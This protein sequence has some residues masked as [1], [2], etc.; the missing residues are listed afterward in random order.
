[1]FTLIAIFTLA[2]G[3]GANTAIF[4]VVRGVLLKPLPFDDADRLVGVWHTAPGI[5]IPELNMSP[6]TYLIYREEGRVFED[7]GLWNG[8]AV[9]VTGSG[10]PE[11]VQA[12]FVTDGTLSLLHVNPILGRHFTADD[13]SPRTP[14]RVLVSHAYWERKFGSDRD[15]VGKSVVVDGKPR[16]IIGVLP[17]G[18]RFP[19]RNP[20]LVLPFR[21]NRSE[22]HAAN[23]SYR[24]VARLKPGTTM[25]QANADV[26][27]LIPV[28]PDRFPMPPGFTRK[29][30]DDVKMGPN[31]RPLAV[32]VVGDIG[33]V[34]WVLLGTVGLVLLIA[35]ANVANLFLVRAEARQ[36]E[37]AI[38]A[39]LGAGSL[40]IAWELLSESL[41]LA[42]AGGLA[43]LGL[44]YAGIRALVANAPEGLPRTAD[45]GIDPIVLAF[46]LGI[47]LLAGVLFGLLPVLKLATPHLASAL[48]EGGRLA[49]A[50]RERH[51][52]RNGLVVAEIAL[53]VV[54]LVA[55]GLMIRTFQ[56][57]R[58]VAPGF[59]R[60]EEVLTLRVSIPES[61][62]A[63]GGQAIRTHEQIVRRIEQIPGVTSVGVSNSIT[64]DGFDSNDP[65][66]VED[67]PPPADTIPPLRRFKFTAQNYFQTMGN[68]IVA[69]RE[70]TWAD[71]HSR[72]SVV[73]VSENFAR[74][75]WKEPAAA[76]GKRIRQTPSNPWRTIIGV[77]GNERD[78]GIAQPATAI[79]YWPLLMN[80][81]W[82]NK[83]FVQR[84][85][86]FA[87]RTDRA[88]SPTLLKEIQQAVWAVN[89]NLPV[90]NV[91]TL[92]QIRA[93]S[94]AQ[95]SFALV[96]L[97]IAAAVALLLGVVGIY[98]V[99]AYVAQQRTKEIG[100]RMALGAASHDVSR[101]FVRH[102]IVLAGI[103]ILCGIGAAALMT[104]AM[105]ALLFG[106]SA[107]DPLT[108]AAVALALG[109][110]ALLASYLPA[111][112]A[113][114][115]DPADA[116]RWEA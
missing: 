46:T 95:T 79:V 32:D 23:F 51:R 2:L 65:I 112:R 10:E 52:A 86:G 72:A 70:M 36:Q 59:V 104:R 67:F 50:G 103:G 44:A 19:D 16:E 107:Y 87:V 27:R 61:I 92:D 57:M 80:D 30:F 101:L 115:I 34:L 74:E 96:M 14:E 73:L 83:L 94:M 38:H 90:A 75:Y 82:N 105:S 81:F 9:S 53:A 106:V 62:V 93:G 71:V 11:R 24:G 8:G 18:F 100:I 7:V 110:T 98:G 68:P 40:R 17:A 28:I 102:G 63:D 69:G 15:V 49:S 25:D 97:G 26:A 85:V 35:C 56:A 84:N 88:E 58:Q 22:L 109:A 5:G 20:Q 42:L 60:P 29:M 1:M 45:I 47:S 43:G 48:K 108:Y 4:S 13:D 66:F 78:N 64:M 114:R 12:L 31:V 91:R 37:L 77:V 116:L 3:I 6:A 21:F 55:C 111:R 113:S 99:I 54:L 89:A 76:I 33:R 41:T 39:A